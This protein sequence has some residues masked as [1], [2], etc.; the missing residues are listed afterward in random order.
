MYILMWHPQLLPER[1]AGGFNLVASSRAEPINN[2]AHPADL[3]PK[4]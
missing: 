4:L 1:A 3:P 2:A